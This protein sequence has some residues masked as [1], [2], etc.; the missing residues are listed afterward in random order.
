MGLRDLAASGG[1]QGVPAMGQ[2][3]PQ[4]A[5][6]S[7][8]NPAGMGP[9]HDRSIPF[10][11]RMIQAG[12]DLVNELRGMD[13]TEAAQIQMMVAKLA[14]TKAKRAQQMQQAAEQMQAM[15]GGGGLPMG[16]M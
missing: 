9:L 16:G 8:Q 6:P 7:V 13:D 3:P 15:T 1:G 4:G 11:D 5:P 12:D 2:V 10:Y 14:T